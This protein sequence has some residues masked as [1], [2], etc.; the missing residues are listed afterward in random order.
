VPFA[1]GIGVKFLGAVMW[2]P[3]KANSA[4]ARIVRRIGAFSWLQRE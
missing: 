3:N 4:V 2:A 1:T